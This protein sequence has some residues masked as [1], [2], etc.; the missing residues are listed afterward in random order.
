ME[1]ALKYD[2]KLEYGQ[3]SNWWVGKD[4]VESD[5]SYKNE[6]HSDDCIWIASWE[7]TNWW[8]NIF[9][10]WYTADSEQF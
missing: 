7:T 8:I 9:I 6:E 2:N 10:P 3:A 5:H 4:S 1:G